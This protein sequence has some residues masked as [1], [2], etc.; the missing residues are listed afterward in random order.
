MDS[1]LLPHH[2]VAT[3]VGAV[4]EKVRAMETKEEQDVYKD[5]AISLKCPGVSG[6]AP[7]YDEKI[8]YWC[9]VRNDRVVQN[10][11][12]DAQD[13]PTLFKGGSSYIVRRR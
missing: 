4:R 3:H 6:L 11:K 8:G 2:R 12:Q 7:T 10:I 13:A 9:A 5:S 1:S